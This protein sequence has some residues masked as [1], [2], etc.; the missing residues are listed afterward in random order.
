M[1]IPLPRPLTHEAAH[2]RT[3]GPGAGAS[4]PR[5]AE[6]GG[7]LNRPPED[8][9]LLRAARS[10]ADAMS[11]DWDPALEAELRTCIAQWRFG[12]ALLIADEL[13]ARERHNARGTVGGAEGRVRLTQA[14][15]DQRAAEI[16]GLVRSAGE[17][18]DRTRLPGAAA[19]VQRRAHA[20]ASTA[21]SAARLDRLTASAAAG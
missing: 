3:H 17:L 12:D 10:I 11:R 20:P 9:R 2:E 1:S 13:D 5:T 18:R 21:V 6:I 19:A 7:E 8:T 14:W 16:V 4:A 15:R